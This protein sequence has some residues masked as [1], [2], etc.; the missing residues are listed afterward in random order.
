MTIKTLHGKF[1]IDVQLFTKKGVNGRISYFELSK[2]FQDDY[3]SN[4]LKEYSAY[5]SNRTSYEEVE[6]MHKRNTG[7][8]LLSDQKIQQ[9]VVNKAVEVSKGIAKEVDSILKEKDYALPKIN[10]EVDIYDTVNKEILLFDDGIQVKGQKENR[11]KASSMSDPSIEAN[12]AMKKKK[13]IRINTDVMF[14][15]KA[16][17]GFEYLIAGIDEAGNELV[18]VENIVKAKIY[19]MDHG[20]V[21]NLIDICDI[22]NL[23]LQVELIFFKIFTHK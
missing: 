10:C 18:S 9:I 4:G 16:E 5:Y 2:Q 1:N 7:E 3:I 23:I 22:I 8:K 14:L 17:G 6:K 20:I 15:E 11:E 13:K 12:E 19:G 21:I